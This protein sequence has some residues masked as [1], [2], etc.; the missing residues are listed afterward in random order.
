MTRSDFDIIVIGAGMAGAGV[1]ALLA[2]HR[3]VLVLEQESQPGFHST[4]RS[5]ALFSQIYGP[6]PVRALSR[7]THA[8]LLDPPAGFAEAPLTRAIG[9]LHVAS[10]EQKAR[11]DAFAALP[12]VG[13][14][15]RKVTGEEARVLCPILREEHV[16]AGVYEAG[17]AEMDVHAIHQGFLR[18]LRARG[19][20][21]ATDHAVESL[22]RTNDR[23]RVAAAG[24]V[25][26]AEIV[27]NAAGAWADLVGALAGAQAI[28]LQPRR[29]TA[30]LVDAPQ[31]AAIETWPMVI[32]A[33]ELWYFKSD[34]G[35]LLLSPADETPTDPCD[36]QPDEWDVAVAVDRI[37]TA[38]TLQVRRIKHRWAGLR[39]FVPDRRPVAGFD[40]QAPGFFWLAGQGGYGIQTCYGLS[41]LAAS[42]VLD[43]VLPSEL[44]EAGVRPAD[45]SPARLL[46]TPRTALSATS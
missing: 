29:R 5:A 28:G 2:E 17:A 23:W 13:H 6:E 38:T 15:T 10:A 1:A 25:F 45:F 22:T 9:A 39:S 16:V 12:D 20:E 4:G 14:A 18:L 24:K 8:F 42:L 34:A 37:E 19:G 27:V 41:R 43:Q 40:G 31:G 33:D 46:A 44:T 32:D 35:L 11:L 7:A 36:A 3:R 30:V 21:L 26:T